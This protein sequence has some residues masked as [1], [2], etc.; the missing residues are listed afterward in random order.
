MKNEERLDKNIQCENVRCKKLALKVIGEAL[1]GR[2]KT[3]LNPILGGL[4]WRFSREEEAA[5]YQH[6]QQHLLNNSYTSKVDTSGLMESGS[7]AQIP[8]HDLIIT[9]KL[10]VETE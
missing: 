7:D 5:H 2:D 3:R 9:G 4:A 10:D 6:V 1:K 8:R